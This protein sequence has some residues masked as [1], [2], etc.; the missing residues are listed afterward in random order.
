M[1]V[2]YVT[3]HLSNCIVALSPQPA[4]S[5]PASLP[6]RT[7]AAITRLNRIRGYGKTNAVVVSGQTPEVPV[8]SKKSGHLYEKRLILKYVD[9]EGKVRGG[10][11]RRP[12]KRESVV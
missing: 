11:K 5:P 9:A 12:K 4:V 10:G 2:L 1:I 3:W 6:G 7:T 8:V